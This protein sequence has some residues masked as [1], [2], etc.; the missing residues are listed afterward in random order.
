MTHVAH[1]Q[2][3]IELGLC[4][5]AIIAYGSTQRS[6]GRKNVAPREYNP[7]ETPYRPVLPAS[8]YA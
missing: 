1:A 6:A 4:E 3:A 7:Y 8:A 2:A 5:V